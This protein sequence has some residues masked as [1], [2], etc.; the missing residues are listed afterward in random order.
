MDKVIRKRD[1]TQRKNIHVATLK[2]IEGF[3]KEQMTPI[4]KSDLVKLIAVDYNSLNMALG[5][6]PIKTDKEGRISIKKRGKSNV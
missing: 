4:Y 3:L 1:P 2:R 6:L 5:M